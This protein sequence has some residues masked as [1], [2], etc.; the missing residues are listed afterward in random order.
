MSI[1]IADHKTGGE[2]LNF[3]LPANEVE[4]DAKTGAFYSRGFTSGVKN[5]PLSASHR[6]S[7]QSDGYDQS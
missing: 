3:R 5:Q 6:F 7:R 1:L 4:T 2:I